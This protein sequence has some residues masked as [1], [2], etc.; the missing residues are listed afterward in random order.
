MAV[1]TTSSQVFKQVLTR[2]GVLV[3]AIA[4]VGGLIGWMTFGPNGLASALIGAAL[5]FVFV[6]LTAASV[7][8]GGRLPLGGFFG[9]VLGTWLVK[10]I[11]FGLTVVW[12]KQADFIH[13]PT[14]FFTLVASVLGTLTIDAL[15]VLKSRVPT[16]NL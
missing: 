2:G 9:V 6:G 10:I 5:A 3:A 12:L 15:V 13:G 14:L 11:G 4:V 7:L 1:A 16:V 8:I